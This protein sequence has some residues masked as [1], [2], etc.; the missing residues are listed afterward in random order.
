MLDDVGV[1]EVS[2]IELE[3]GASASGVDAMGGAS[4]ANICENNC[5]LS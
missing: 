1:L 4:G 2:A 3:G 5:C